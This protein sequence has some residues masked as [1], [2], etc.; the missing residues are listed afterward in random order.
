MSP[1]KRRFFERFRSLY[2]WHRYAG[3]LA[4]VLAAW[5]ALTGIVL[6]HADDLRLA[7][8]SV[9]QRWLMDVYNVEPP[10]ALSSQRIGTHWLTATGGVV[11]LDDQRIAAGEWAGGTTTEF[12]FVIAL[13]D[14]LQLYTPEAERIEELPFTASAATIRAIGSTS[15]G[16]VVI[17]GDRAF[18]ANAE[19][20][21][22][23]P[24]ERD[25]D[26]A[27][28]QLQPLPAELLDAVGRDLVAQALDW[29]RVMLDLH[30][31]RL[32]GKAGVWLADLAGA[33]LLLLAITGVIVWWQRARTRRAHR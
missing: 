27:S 28:P 7:D 10:A 32:F 20:T 13:P 6:N 16:I 5:L 29:E 18:V 33:L 19:F 30:S 23:E 26:L 9:E 15:E 21:A 2:L 14:R 24:L 1:R 31:G 8:Q 4:A 22:F 25:I 17:A 3:L 11:Y 12:G